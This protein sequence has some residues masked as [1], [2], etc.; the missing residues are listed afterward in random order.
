M[1]KPARA[2]VYTAIFG[3][4]DTLKRPPVQDMRC[5]FVCFT[6]D[7]ESLKPCDVWSIIEARRNPNEHPR[8]QAKWFKFMSH[9]IFPG[10]RLAIWYDSRAA[11]HERYDAVIW[12]DGS[13]QIK[14]ASFVREFVDS[15]GS[16]GWAL[17]K[18][19][20]RD[21]IYEE[22]ATAVLMPKYNGQPILEQVAHYR[23][24]GHPVH[25]GLFACGAIVRTAREHLGLIVLNEAW[26]RETRQWSHQD[27]LSLPFLLHQLRLSVDLV[28]YNLWHNDW[29][30]V[31]SYNTET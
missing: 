17:F 4:Y 29:F 15:I 12:I 25:G 19:P 26:W 21:C 11:P 28:H 5:D 23:A 30:D 8:I 31:I 1:S 20:D 7:A 16:S 13:I 6:D 22:A 18:H 14:S 9:R 24:L 2:I 27:Q 10:G 3:G